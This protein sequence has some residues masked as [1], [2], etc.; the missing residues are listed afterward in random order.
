MRPVLCPHSFIRLEAKKHLYQRSLA[1]GFLE[2]IQRRDRFRE[3]GMP[4][5]TKITESARINR[6]AV[7]KEGALQKSPRQYSAPKM[8]AVEGKVVCLATIVVYAGQPLSSE[9]ILTECRHCPDHG[10]AISYRYAARQ[11]DREFMGG[12]EPEHE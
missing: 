8:Y 6:I 12:I 1:F 11:A 9:I 3:S 5:H 2:L 10:K 7:G 4:G